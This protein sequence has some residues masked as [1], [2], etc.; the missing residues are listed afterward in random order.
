MILS[1][2]LKMFCGEGPIVAAEIG[3]EHGTSAMAMIQNY[4][5]IEQY[6][7]I[8]PWRGRDEKYERVKVLLESTGKAT[9]LRMTSDE[10]VNHVPN[11]L[12]FVYIDGDHSYEQVLRDLE[13]WVPK[14][15]S[16]GI[17]SGHDWCKFE[18]GVVEAGTEYFPK[19]DHLFKPIFSDKE[20]K[21]M[22]LGMWRVGCRG[23]LNKRRHSGHPSWFRIKK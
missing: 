16:G 23:Y 20:L 5:S 1:D 2:M 11:N 6:Y 19:N 15:R 4:E 13:N 22:G 3:I 14:I 9:V 17:I 12:D 21:E 8:D 10:A 7:C 18:I